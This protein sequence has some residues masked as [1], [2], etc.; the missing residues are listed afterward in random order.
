MLNQLIPKAFAQI[1]IEDSFGPAQNYNTVG[2]LVNV[3]L[4][5]IF[6]IA[7][8]IALLGIVISGLNLIVHAGNAEAEKTNKDRAAFT[9]ALVGLIIIVGAYFFIQIIEVLTGIKILSPL[10]N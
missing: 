6:T 1:K 7:G 8:V 9:A 5:N 10:V 4:K 2:A 3:L